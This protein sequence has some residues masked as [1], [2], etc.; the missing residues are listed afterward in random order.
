MNIS[1][2]KAAAADTLA[3]AG[4]ANAGRE[5]A[6][7]LVFVLKKDATFLIAH[8]EFE[9]TENDVAAFADVTARRANREPFQ[10]ITGVQE[11]YGLEFEVSADVLIP[12]PETEILVED[13]IELLSEVEKP[14][15]FEV[16]VG[17][18][19]ISIS[20]L[21][22]V[23]EATSSGTDISDS[24]LAVAARNA[25]RH[26]VAPRLALRRGDVFEGADQT[27]DLIVSNPPY[28]PDD[29]L[30]QPEVG[31]FEPPVALFGGPDGLDIV[32]RIVDKTPKY[33]KP[34]C[35]LLIEIGFDQ[36]GSVK[37][38]FDPLVWETVE[39]LPDLQGFPRIVKARLR[40]QDN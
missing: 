6:S 14:A 32:R 26:G 34:S 12:R 27:Y 40:R 38:M 37:E 8:P 33:L 24:A 21:N 4:V 28:I 30:L 11:F 3:N 9:L 13:S 23:A 19:C 25:E 39:F 16:G 31:E 20:I 2:A 29:E 22:E 5:A 18:G 17:S 7:L 36:S 10:Y 15:F 1:G 35:F